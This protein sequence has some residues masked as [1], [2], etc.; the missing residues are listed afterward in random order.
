MTRVSRAAWGALALGVY[1]L[2]LGVL[3]G[4][5]LL[6]LWPTVEGFTSATTPSQLSIRWFG[7]SFSLGAEAALLL[8]VLV[9]G[10]LGAYIHTV[11]SF[12]DY[13]GNR[14]LTSSWIWWYFLRPFIGIALA[15]VFYVA[16]RGGFFA[17]EAQTGDVNPF[18]MAALA[19]LAGLFSKQATDK[20]KEV[21]DTLFRTAE[22]GDAHR[23]DPLANP[24]PTLE[25][26]EPTSIDTGEE[27]PVLRLQGDHFVRNS[28][29]LLD[30]T[31]IRPEYLGP[32]ELRVKVRAEDR[33][34]PGTHNVKVRNPEPGGGVSEPVP[35][36][37]T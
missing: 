1:L 20:L 22:G 13:V 31:P 8:L 2:V 25:S 21:F 7:T 12:V 30:G 32:T 36:Q 10:A 33:L 3:L 19:G 24:V 34:D 18:G 15:L 6:A 29:V 26:I 5:F 23:R 16:I 14:R 4:S 28:T 37:L 27:A 35:V 11:T 17:Q 9:F